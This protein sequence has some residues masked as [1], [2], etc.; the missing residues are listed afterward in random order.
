MIT[1]SPPATA[2]RNS[3]SFALAS[4]MLTIFMVIIMT[5]YTTLCQGFRT[6]HQ[7]SAISHLLRAW[8]LAIQVRGVVGEGR[9]HDRRLADV[10]DVEAI[11]GV[12]VRM[13]RAD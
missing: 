13:V 1:V 4:L 11:G 7:P 8:N 3:D 10:R 2:S 9:H 6:S 5:F 12:H